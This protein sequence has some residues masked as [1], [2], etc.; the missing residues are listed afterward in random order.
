[1]S[2]SSFTSMIEHFSQ[3][4]LPVQGLVTGFGYLLGIIFFIIGIRKLKTIADYRARS[5][6]NQPIIVPIAYF[7]GA[8]VLIYIPEAIKV[9]S[10]TTF[11]AGNI[12]AYQKVS[13]VSV[14]GSMLLI[15]QTAGI[16][17]FVRGTSLLVNASNPGIQH[18]AKGLTFLIAGIL[19]INFQGTM[20]TINTAMQWAA[21]YTLAFKGGLGY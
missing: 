19:A 3:S 8:A 11:G 6:S 12:L 17:W 4:A 10:T 15:I 21:S 1:M 13:T 16:I 20:S 9:A 14:L 18:G 5:S 2:D 7:L